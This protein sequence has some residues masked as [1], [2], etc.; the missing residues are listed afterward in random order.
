M[1]THTLAYICFHKDGDNCSG[2]ILVTDD[3]GVP[4]EY[5]YTDP[6][7]PTRFQSILYGKVLESYVRREVIATNLL[8]K[9]DNKPD[10]FVVPDPIDFDVH[11]ILSVP[12][13]AIES[14]RESVSSGEDVKFL[15]DSEF[16]VACPIT[17]TNF[18]VRVASP[19]TRRNVAE[20]LKSAARKMDIEEPVERVVQALQEM[21]RDSVRKG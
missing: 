5:K 13:A 19:E 14:T 3:R 15:G 11:D 2:G 12:L 1:I 4:L 21:S 18:K 7:R 6:V 9:I 16:I 17:G 8:S 20:L 10:L